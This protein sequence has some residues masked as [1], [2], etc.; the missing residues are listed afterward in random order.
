MSFARGVRGSRASN[1]SLHWSGDCVGT[2]GGPSPRQLSPTA[3]GSPWNRWSRSA[4]GPSPCWLLHARALSSRLATARVALCAERRF[5]HE[6]CTSSCCASKAPRRARACSALVSATMV[7]RGVAARNYF[8]PVNVGC[9]PTH[10]LGAA[11][12]KNDLP[13]RV[14]DTLCTIPTCNPPTSVL[15][16]YHEDAAQRMPLFAVPTSPRTISS[17]C[18]GRAVWPKVR[19]KRGLP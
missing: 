16:G 12:A 18:R 15:G 9:N 19:N 4:A 6:R 8:L 14:D 5:W 1:W 7:Q 3:S 13:A 10:D 2:R 11:R 17:S